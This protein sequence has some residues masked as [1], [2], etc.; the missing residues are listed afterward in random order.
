ML[1]S[2]P[3][4]FD[5]AP[6][7][8]T[9]V[10][11]WIKF[12]NLPLKYWSLKCLSKIVSVLGKPLQCDKLT[13]MMSRLSCA[14]V[15]VEL[16]L[17]SNLI[18]SINIILPNSA[19]LVQSVVYENLSKLYKHIIIIIIIAITIIINYYYYHFFLSECKY[20]LRSKVTTLDNQQV[21]IH[22]QDIQEQKRKQTLSI[23]E[24]TCS[25]KRLAM[26]SPKQV[27]SNG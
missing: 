2:V 5:F 10:P 27:S 23:K 21:H 15:L 17:L 4:Y 9:R 22:A 16:D 12:P 26:Q 14:R 13:S 1:K 19:T 18:Y 11:I 3:E 6:D 7:E 20:V 25:H 24:G 8:M